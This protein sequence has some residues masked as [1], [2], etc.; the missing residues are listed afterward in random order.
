[1]AAIEVSLKIKKT[2]I[3]RINIELGSES[4]QNFFFHFEQ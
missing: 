3:Y 4:G 2:K 1:M